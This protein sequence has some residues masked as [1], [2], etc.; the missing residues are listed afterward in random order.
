MEQT[1]RCYGVVETQ[2]AKSKGASILPG[3]ITAVDLHFEPWVRQH[4]FAGLS[5]DKYPNLAKWLESLG[6]RQEVKE[7]YRKIQEAPKPGE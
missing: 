7:A 3:G 1:Y 6:E 5:L 2:L 4:K